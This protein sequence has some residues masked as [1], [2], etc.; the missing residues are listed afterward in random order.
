MVV[1]QAEADANAHV[2]SQDHGRQKILAAQAVSL[3]NGENRR[4]AC[5]RCMNDRLVNDGRG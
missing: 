2:D 4:D 1:T 5:R 3:G